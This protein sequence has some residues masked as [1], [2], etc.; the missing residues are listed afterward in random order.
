MAST[1]NY[2]RC[3]LFNLKHIIYDITSTNQYHCVAN[4]MLHELKKI[5]VQPRYA[6][7]NQNNTPS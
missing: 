5:N 7:F 4:T 1:K 6:I 3:I 2:S